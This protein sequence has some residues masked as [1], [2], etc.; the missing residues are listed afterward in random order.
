MLLQNLT[1]QKKSNPLIF[2]MFLQ[3]E[4]GLASVTCFCSMKPQ[5]MCPKK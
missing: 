5:V 4:L 1:V 2:L 3:C